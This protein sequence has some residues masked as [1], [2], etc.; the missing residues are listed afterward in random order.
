MAKAKTESSAESGDQLSTQQ[1]AAS[2]DALMATA[3]IDSQIA[4]LVA[5]ADTVAVIDS[6]TVNAALNEALT[7]ALQR[8][9]LGLHHLRHTVSWQTDGA[10]AE[11]VFAVGKQEVAHLSA[12]VDQ[13]ATAYAPL[14]ALDERGLS[15]WGALPEG[16]RAGPDISSASLKAL[17]EDAREFETQW[18]TTRGGFFQRVWRSKDTLFIEVA[19]P[20]SA[21]TA[22][23]DAAWDV[24]ASIKDRSFQRELMQRSESM[25]MLGALL[26]ARH[27]EA[28]ANLERL[29]EAH[30]ALQ[31]VVHTLK[32]D[33]GRSMAEYRQQLKNA[34]AEL[35]EYQALVTKQLAD[36]LRHGLRE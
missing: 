7:V 6:K 20:A 15:L 13:L 32:G 9:G 27:N 21:K 22:L 8:W 5:S 25:G 31:A 29:P 17:I 4:A 28:K 10:R 14:M 1:L 11:I 18:L 24:I 30:F 2:F 16:Y 19:R 33:Q 35:S 36:V 26:G 3:A 23:A 12:G 34:S